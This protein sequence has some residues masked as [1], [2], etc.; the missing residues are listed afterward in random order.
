MVEAGGKD[1]PAFTRE[2]DGSMPK[3][4]QPRANGEQHDKLRATTQV[5]V[6]NGHS[7]NKSPDETK[8]DVPEETHKSSTTATHAKQNGI[9][10][11]GNDNSFFNNSCTSVQTNGGGGGEF[12]SI[13]DFFFL[14]KLQQ[15]RNFIE[16]VCGDFPRVWNS[17]WS[18]SNGVSCR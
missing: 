3:N 11:G 4:G 15:V 12:N 17:F 1:N 16:L 6:A 18:R 2:E 13:N 7:N 5:V 8:I 14:L 9:N 10:G